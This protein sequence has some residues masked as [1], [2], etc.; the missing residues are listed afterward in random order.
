MAKV[1]ILALT[2]YLIGAGFCELIFEHK[3]FQLSAAASPEKRENQ[4]LKLLNVSEQQST[5]TTNFNQQHH[6]LILNATVNV[7]SAIAAGAQEQQEGQHQNARHWSNMISRT[8]NPAGIKDFVDIQGT[9]S[10]DLGVI[11][12]NSTSST[13][14]SSI[15][16]QQ[17][18]PSIDL[19]ATYT[20]FP[21]SQH[22]VDQLFQP[23]IGCGPLKSDINNSYTVRPTEEL[24][25]MFK[26]AEYRALE[27]SL[28]GT[29][30]LFALPKFDMGSVKQFLP[31]NGGVA[32][33]ANAYLQGSRAPTVFD[34]QMIYV[35]SGC[36]SQD[37]S[38]FKMWRSD[39]E[40]KR[41]EVQLD[42]VVLL[43]QFWGDAYFHA[44]V[45]CLPRIV[46]VLDYLRANPE[47][48]ILVGQPL[49][50]TR[51]TLNKRFGLSPS[52]R[53]MSYLTTKTYYAKQLLIPTGT[54]CG[55]AQTAAVDELQKTIASTAIDE[56]VT[57]NAASSQQHT[58]STNKIVLLHKRKSRKILNHEELLHA[59]IQANL[60]T[61]HEFYGDESLDDTIAL[62]HAADV[63]IGPHGAGFANLIYSNHGAGAIEL[64]QTYGNVN[65]DEVNLCHQRTAAAAGLRSRLLVQTDG[66]RFTDFKVNVTEAVEA[67]RKL[68]QE[69]A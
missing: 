19:N 55:R 31:T 54:Q 58:N 67:V 28:L 46:Y 44:T 40:H 69:V 56:V 62:H 33:F 57:A 37:G 35:P 47:T 39:D 10:I 15:N 25:Q 45:E 2:L 11:F 61:V 4:S 7:S 38:S 8:N 36:K 9:S 12:D 32:L 21:S 26:R 24:Q 30:R 59:L 68:L 1:I 48:V 34:C 64:H 53:W 16:M 14:E 43:Y 42:T 49:Y 66:S 52:Q 63:I 6:H 17:E 41:R 27:S 18:M 20:Q 22:Q 51:F 23:L 29:P 13:N 3:Y 60:S 65:G 50:K 5:H